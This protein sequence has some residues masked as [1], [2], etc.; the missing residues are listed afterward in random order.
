MIKSYLKTNTPLILILIC[1]LT[2]SAISIFY[3]GDFTFDEMF[4]THYSLL[5]WVDAIKYWVM[6]TN[7]PLHTLL[8]RGWLAIFGNTEIISRSLSVIF[9]AGS[10][11]LLYTF[12]RNFLSQKHAVLSSSILIF[13]S[14]FIHLSTEARSYSLFLFLTIAS[15]YLFYSIFFDNKKSTGRTI[16]YI[17]V[18]TLL[19]FTHLTAVLIPVIQLG[20]LILKDE[21]RKNN[22]INFFITH[23]APGILFLIWF[24]PSFLSKLGSNASSGWFFK[25]AKYGKNILTGLIP[26]FVESPQNVIGL[27][28]SLGLLGI[29]VYTIFHIYKKRETDHILSIIFLWTIVPIIIASLFGIYISK[30][31][32]FCLPGF[33]ILIAHAVAQLKDKRMYYVTI[34]L[35]ASILIPSAFSY[36]S[37]PLKSWKEITKFISENETQNSK[38]FSVPFN[39]ELVINKYYHGT[40]PVVGIYPREDSMNLDERMV[41]YNW[42]EIEVTRPDFEKYMR[43]TIGDADKIFFL[44]YTSNIVAPPVPRWFIQNDWVLTDYLKSKYDMDPYVFEFT[45]TNSATTSTLE[46][47]ANR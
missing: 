41:R 17:I 16:L 31:I 30:Y 10:I 45:K 28:I 34:L 35:I 21:K 29:L 8:L 38:I 9:S 27:I 4:S 14:S 40:S 32:T 2:I 7:P 13:S 22:I 44:Q 26:L 36:A 37:T 25:E 24:V 15:F 42:Q 39:Q 20:G 46:L 11:I 3:R 23:I 19:L 33:A 18:Q 12:A 43:N 6:E 1:S 47:E 5:P